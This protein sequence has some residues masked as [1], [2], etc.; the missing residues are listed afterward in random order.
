MAYYRFTKND[1]FHAQIRTYPKVEFLVYSGSV[2]YN[3]KGADKGES[4]ANIGHVGIGG[5]NLYELNVDRTL[6]SNHHLGSSNLIKPFISKGSDLASFKT[7]AMTTFDSAY[8]YGDKIWGKYPLTSSISVDQYFTLVSQGAIAPNTTPAEAAIILNQRR[9]LYA[10]KS[11]LEYYKTLH[12]DY[13]NLTYYSEP[14]TLISIPSIFYGSTIRKGSV[15]LR[16]YI[17]GSLAAEVTDERY[18]G[19]L[20]QNAHGSATN[21]SG[22]SAGV[23]LYN[24]GF[25]ILTGS[26]SLDGDHEEKYDPSQAND[27]PRWKYFAATGSSA[28]TKVPKSAFEISFEGTTYIPTL[29]MLAHANK[30]KLNNSSNVTFLESNQSA[31]HGAAQTSSFEYKERDDL[32]IKNIVSSSYDVPSASFA[33]ETYISS[34]GIYDKDKNLIGVAKLARPVRKTEDR[35]FTF[36]M[37]LDF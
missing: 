7:V 11:T 31:S 8:V 27:S 20:I 4:Q 35:H 36:K 12:L 5:I 21:G 13:G 15:K 29:T 14:L 34:I 33:K 28:A 3:G 32:R 24:E 26:W 17:N 30:G 19:T 2:F 10:L 16:F 25:V 22:S 6:D 9:R 1:V 18:D 23:V 37:K